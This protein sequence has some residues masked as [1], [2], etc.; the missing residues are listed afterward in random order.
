MSVRR[1][2]TYF[3]NGGTICRRPLGRFT[4]SPAASHQRAH[5]NLRANWPQARQQTTFDAMNCFWVFLTD[6]FI[7]GRGDPFLVQPARRAFGEENDGANAYA[8]NDKART[9]SERD[10]YAAIYRKAPAGRRSVRAALERVGGGFW[11]VADHRWQCGARIE[12]SDQPTSYGGAVGADYRFSPYT[13]AGFA[14]AGGGTNFVRQRLGQRTLRPVPGRR[15]RAPHR[16]PGLFSGALAYG[17][18]DITTDRTVTVAGADQLRAQVQR[19]RIL[20]ARRRRLSFCLALDRRIG[21]TP[22]AAG[23]VHHLRSACLCRAG[24]RSA[25]T[26]LRS[27]TAPRMS[28]LAHRTWLA[29]RQILR[30]AGCHLHPART[31]SLGA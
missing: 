26:L 4:P 14:L 11:R 19:Q 16:R 3:N 31:C 27:P 28:R 5:D 12:H 21:I 1:L 13:I 22:Y 25:P 8:A 18:Q 15:L 24:G 2:Q 20:R 10:A 9:K 23:A 7:A 30:D 17:W 29:H 6:P